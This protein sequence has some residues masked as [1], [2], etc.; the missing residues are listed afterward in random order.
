[1]SSNLHGCGT[2]I[3][4]QGLLAGERTTRLLGDS[5]LFPPGSPEQTHGSWEPGTWFGAPAPGPFAMDVDPV[6]TLA[7]LAAREAWHAAGL[8]EVRLAPERI[9]CVVGTSKG[10][11]RLFA[12]LFRQQ[13]A[14]VGRE[15]VPD[16][17]GAWADAAVRAVVEE[18]G[19]AG[20]QLC[21]VAACATGVSSLIRGAALLRADLCDVV[22]AGSSD[23]SLQPAVLASFRR[24]GV[25]A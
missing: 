25:L 5:V 20:P 8:T 2:R 10:G 23:A 14:S 6:A 11:I 17:R 24:L 9:G 12:D 1:R 21:P 7:R 18:L 22:V 3:S 15:A 19:A 16:W 4:W 13:R